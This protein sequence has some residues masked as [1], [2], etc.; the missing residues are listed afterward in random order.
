GF[1]END[2]V[3]PLGSPETP[4]WTLPANCC[5]CTSIDA[6]AAFPGANCTLSGV[7]NVKLGLETVRGKVVVTVC[8]PHVPLTVTVLVPAAADNSAERLSATLW[9]VGFTGKEAVTPA[10]NPLIERLTLPVKPSI[11]FTLT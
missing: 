7:D 9:L 2:A 3:T 4:S 8:D 10:G 5:P 6:V 1:G 11:W